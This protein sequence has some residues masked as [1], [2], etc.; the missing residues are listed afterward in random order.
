M[1][2]FTV[3]T[4]TCLPIINENIDTDQIVPA[5]FLKIT[6]REGFGRYLF[7]DWRFDQVGRARSNNKFDSSNYGTAKILVVGNNF[8]CGSSRE[9]AVWAIAD[10]GFRVVIS[11]SFG[12]IFYNN[13]LKN[14]LLCV[15]LKPKELEILFQV[16]QEDK[17]I[18]V[19]VDLEKQALILRPIMT[20]F[21][22]GPLA[23]AFGTGQKLVFHFDIDSF[24][25]RCLIKGV[26]ELGYI[27]SFEERISEYEAR[28]FNF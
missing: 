2:T 16:I 24:R 4:S 3:I 28:I 22:R 7:Y 1:N 21:A 8:G 19:T 13:A 9:H 10:Y 17:N 12:D 15:L 5:R 11:S 18:E 20:V 26:D 6:K 25:K 27:L 23:N 14:A